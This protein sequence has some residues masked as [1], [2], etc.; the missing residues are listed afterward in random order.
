M[1]FQCD[2]VK[3]TQCA[4][5]DRQAVEGVGAVVGYVSTVMSIH[6]PHRADR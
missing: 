3:R 2:Y 5:R 1:L 4:P 6:P